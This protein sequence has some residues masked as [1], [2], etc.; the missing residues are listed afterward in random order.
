MWF[1]AGS[2]K[3]TLASG[4]IF[5]EH[6]TERY[7]HM[8]M[9]GGEMCRSGGGGKGP[10]VGSKSRKVGAYSVTSVVSNSLQ[11]HGL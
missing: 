4:Q 10:Q 7:R 5:T 3:Y 11:S 8:G 2:F 9:A 6:H 1:N